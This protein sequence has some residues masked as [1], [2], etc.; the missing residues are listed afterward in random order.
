MV[1]GALQ[2]AET[3]KVLLD[4][5]TPGLVTVDLW[6]GEFER[7]AVAAGPSSD[8][9]ACQGR[10][11]FLD[12]RFGVRTTSLC[13]QNAVQVL[14]AGDATLSFDTLARNLRAIGEVAY[15]EFMLRFKVDGYEMVIFPDARAIVKGTDDESTA[16]SL[17]AKYVGM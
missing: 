16:R 2:A 4:A 6:S 17:Y 8:C 11:E 14:G 1:V 12:A 7:L 13:G 9:P 5:A 10:Y 15:N 3:I